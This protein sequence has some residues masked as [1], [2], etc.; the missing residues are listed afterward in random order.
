MVKF[1]HPVSL[2]SSPTGILI[3]R[4]MQEAVIDPPG[5]IERCAIVR[6]FDED[7]L[8]KFVHVE[9]PSS[10]MESLSRL[11]MVEA[12]AY[13]FALHDLVRD[14]ICEELSLRSIEQYKA[15]NHEAAEYYR[16]RASNSTSDMSQ[17]SIIEMVYH[18]MR[19]NEDEGVAQLRV[20]FTNLRGIFANIKIFSDL[21]AAL[22]AT[23]NGLALRDLNRAWIE[24]WE[25]ELIQL[26]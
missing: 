12:R 19:A 17:R 7:T 22:L 11:S 20:I 26:S 9:N 23:V 16:Q 13:G 4:F 14:T 2:L 6:W 15:L 24:Q 21:G 1:H 10:G 25:R 5:W 8:A 3:R 18:L